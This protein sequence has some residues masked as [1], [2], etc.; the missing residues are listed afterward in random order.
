MMSE[1]PARIAVLI[2]GHGSN[3]QAI[4]DACA[5]GRLPA[6]VVLVVSNRREAY[7]LKRAQMAGVPTAYLP[8]KPYLA[9]GRGRR[10]YDADLA[11]V[12]AQAQPDWIALAGWMHVLGEAFL[13]RFAGRVIN[14]HPALPGQFPGTDAIARAYQAFREGRI[15]HTGVMIHFVPDEA[16]DAGPVIMSEVVPIYPADTPESLEARVHAVEHR[17]Y[18]EALG[19]LIAQAGRP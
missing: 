8:L 9:D 17:L 1:V 10:Q 18:V 14:L 19:R 2:S 16:V 12:V 13:R 6:R 4:M 5:D 7:G 15:A 11:E 3:L